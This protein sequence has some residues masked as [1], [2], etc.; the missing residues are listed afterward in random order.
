MKKRFTDAEK[1]RQPWFRALSPDAKHAWSYLCDNCDV[2]GV[3]EADTALAD[4]SI[5]KALDWPA[6]FAEFGAR[7][8]ELPGGKWW[9]RKFVE[10][11]YGILKESCPPHR[12][13]IACIKKHG[14]EVIAAAP[15]P[16]P[17]PAPAAPADPARSPTA[18]DCIDALAVIQGIDLSRATK[19]TLEKVMHAWREIKKIQPDVTAAMVFLARDRYRQ[20]YKSAPVTAMGLANH[21]SEITPR[22]PS[23]EEI[24]E[25]E[26]LKRQLAE[27]E[28]Q[29]APLMRKAESGL[30]TTRDDLTPEQIDEARDL[31]DII[32]SI[33]AQL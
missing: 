10:F 12:G 9:I 13:I 2:A 5:G 14:L 17:K 28:R 31:T 3:W 20:K 33:K 8:T 27:A 7:V 26:R 29:L 23:E 19:T 25:R 16:E 21:W 30:M 6:A 4:F 15:A 32:A 22:P 18:V 1:W 11:Q 24:E